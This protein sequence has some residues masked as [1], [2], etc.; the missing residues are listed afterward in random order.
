M[1]LNPLLIDCKYKVYCTGSSIHEKPILTNFKIVPIIVIPTC[2]FLIKVVE[3][4]IFATKP[5]DVMISWLLS[6]IMTKSES[7]LSVINDWEKVHS[8][9]QLLN[10]HWWQWRFPLSCS[11]SKI[12]ARRYKIIKATLLS[13][14]LATLCGA[15][16]DMIE[17]T[18]NLLSQ[19]TSTKSIFHES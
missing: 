2:P 17:E 9:Y 10:S 6:K 1:F 16:Y 15:L 3:V 8:C 13:T 12:D 18:L 4:P 19:Q 14:F 11:S 5:I 7:W